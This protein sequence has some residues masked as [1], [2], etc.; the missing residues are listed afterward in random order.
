M[1]DRMFFCKDFFIFIFIF[2]FSVRIEL[3]RMGLLYFTES[4][5]DS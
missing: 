3:S 4:H 5:L 1:N 2:F